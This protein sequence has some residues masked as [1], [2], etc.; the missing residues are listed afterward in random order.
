MP[1]VEHEPARTQVSRGAD[2][3]SKLFGSQGAETLHVES[4][5]PVTGGLLR[6][7]KMNDVIDPPADLSSAAHRLTRPLY[8]AADRGGLERPWP[9]GPE[10]RER[11]VSDPGRRRQP[12]PT[13]QSRASRPRQLPDSFF[14]VIGNPRQDVGARGNL[15]R[16]DQKPADSNQRR[17]SVDGAEDQSLDG[18]P[19]IQ[20]GARLQAQP[21]A[22]R[23]GA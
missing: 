22:H 21:I 23:P 14:T 17:A 3:L 16:V 4:V 20:V 7:V 11:S 8:S 5:E 12:E 1:V 18:F 13:C 15:S 6:A 2:A 9:P 10:W 19:E